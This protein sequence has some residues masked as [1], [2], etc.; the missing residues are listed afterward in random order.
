MLD[1]PEV[2]QAFV[3]TFQPVTNESKTKRVTAQNR[4]L[5]LRI[6][7]GASCVQRGKAIPER[8]LNFS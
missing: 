8:R 3:G 6:I 4:S 5:N 2:E 1:G 7:A